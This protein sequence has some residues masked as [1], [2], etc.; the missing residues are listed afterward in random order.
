MARTYS[1]KAFPHRVLFD[2]GEGAQRGDDVKVL[3]RHI[4]R[5]LDARDIDRKVGPPNGVY[6]KLIRDA[7]GRPGITWERRTSG[8]SPTPG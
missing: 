1:Q 3:R 5:R 4:L 8:W 7:A 6:S 2:T